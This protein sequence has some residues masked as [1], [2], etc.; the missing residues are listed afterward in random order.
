MTP[1]F[2]K[3]NMPE[4]D[5]EQGEAVYKA[6]KMS[7]GVGPRAC[8]EKIR[9]T[10]P[11][12]E[13]PRCNKKKN[14]NS[15]L[16]FTILRFTRMKMLAKRYDAWIK[17]PLKTKV[18]FESYARNHPTTMSRAWPDTCRVLEGGLR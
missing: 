12:E 11:C 16:E 17:H 3:K 6:R 14:N 10:I 2:I 5:K 7:L 9:M 8:V 1:K 18:R 4:P 15:A 13:F